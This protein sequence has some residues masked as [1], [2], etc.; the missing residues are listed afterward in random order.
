ML[1]SLIWMLK[2]ECESSSL[3]CASSKF[4]WLF[5]HQIHSFHY[6]LR[7]WLMC[8]T[9][10]WIYFSFLWLRESC[11]LA[12]S[13]WSSSWEC[14]PRHLHHC[15]HLCLNLHRGEHVHERSICFSNCWSVWISTDLFSFLEHSWL[16]FLAPFLFPFLSLLFPFLSSFSSPS[17][18][19]LQNG[20]E[21]MW[22]DQNWKR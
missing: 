15:H 19:L 14:L 11:L 9:N 12:S 6:L 17:F 10:L 18:H 1:R 8:H 16:S 13:S 2:H 7:I 21:T 5:Q 22:S 20:S 3:V 4:K